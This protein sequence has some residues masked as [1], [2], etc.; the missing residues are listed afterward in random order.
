MNANFRNAG[1]GIGGRGTTRRYGKDNVA[2]ERG[3]NRIDGTGKS[4]L[5]HD[6]HTHKLIF[7]QSRIRGDDCQRGVFARTGI[8]T[9]YVGLRRPGVR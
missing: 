7:L 5:R 1:N 9:R 2:V 6:R 8:D 3:V 4:D